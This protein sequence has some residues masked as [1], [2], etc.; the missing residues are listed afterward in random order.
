MTAKGVEAVL[1]TLTLHGPF[2]IGGGARA[3]LDRALDRSVPLPGSSLK[4][5]MRAE[6]RERLCVPD[7]MIDAVFG[8]GGSRPS[9]WW[10]SDAIVD[11][12]Y[13][14]QARI[15]RTADG[16]V[17]RGFLMV[18]EVA[19]AAT[20]AARIEPIADAAQEEHRVVLRA[21]ARSV[22]ALGGGRRRGAGWVSITDDDP[23][24]EA[25]SRQLLKLEAQP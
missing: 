13:T 1:L 18:G 19:W 11:A 4:G 20:A 10:W 3:G 6:A 14:R 15:R 21:A 24:T 8:A 23:W 9:P 25:D 17:D 7:A 5:L 2:R 12:Q 16:V 22:S